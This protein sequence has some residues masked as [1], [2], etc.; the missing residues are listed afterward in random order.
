[1]KVVVG[2]CEVTKVNAKY[3]LDKNK[4]KTKYEVYK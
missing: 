2:F 3:V 1:M 4:L